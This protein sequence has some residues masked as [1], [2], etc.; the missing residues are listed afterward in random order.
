MFITVRGPTACHR[1]R[2]RPSLSTF[3]QARG[4]RLTPGAL[5]AEERRTL[6]HSAISWSWRG[7]SAFNNTTAG[8][9]AWEQRLAPAFRRRRRRFCTHVT[10]EVALL[11]T[12][13]HLSYGDEIFC[14]RCMLKLI[15]VMSCNSFAR[16]FLSLVLSKICREFLLCD[17]KATA[18][19][20]AGPASAFIEN[21]FGFSTS[22]ATWLC[23]RSTLAITGD[24]ATR[25]ERRRQYG[26]TQ[27]RGRIDAVV[28][29]PRLS[30]STSYR[31]R[32]GQRMYCHHLAVHRPDARLFIAIGGK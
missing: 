28:G 22:S 11:S 3:Q 30:V 1:H 23:A 8:V 7:L 29:A 17:Q 27:F 16:Y 4:V 5:L 25:D 13:R 32:V 6:R 19:R 9:S 12:R 20:L 18:A 14:T 31:T 26:T 2:Q 21:H 15:L 10:D 24:C